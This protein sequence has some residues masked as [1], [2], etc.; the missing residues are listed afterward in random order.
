MLLLLFLVMRHV[1]LLLLK[2]VVM[3]MVLQLLVLN[4]LMPRPLHRGKPLL[5]VGGTRLAHLRTEISVL[6][7]PEYLC[8]RLT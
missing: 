5:V 3:M 7:S 6:F 2:L 4:L 8:S 1:V